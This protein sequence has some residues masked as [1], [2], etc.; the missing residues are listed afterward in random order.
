[1]TESSA[2]GLRLAAGRQK[3]HATCPGRGSPVLAL[4]HPPSDVLATQVLRFP[5]PPPPPGWLEP[6]L[7]ENR[8]ISSTEIQTMMWEQPGGAGGGAG[9]GGG[10]L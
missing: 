9:G 3:G 1:M 8:S 5:P 6:T 10:N 7:I 4:S 2:Q